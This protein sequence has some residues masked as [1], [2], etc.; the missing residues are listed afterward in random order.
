VKFRDHPLLPFDELKLSPK[1][2]QTREDRLAAL[3]PQPLKLSRW[4]R[5]KKFLR[6][7]EPDARKQIAVDGIS[8]LFWWL[9]GLICAG[10]ILLCTS[11]PFR[12]RS[13]DASGS[14]KPAP[15]EQQPWTTSIKTDAE[16]HQ[17]VA[18]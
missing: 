17:G 7:I 9:V 6:E 10:I 2:I 13:Q 14:K 8:N 15:L 12:W 4:K 5:F 3:C 18:P 16:R 11:D 1:E